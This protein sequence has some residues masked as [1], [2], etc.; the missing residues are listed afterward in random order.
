MRKN[1][2]RKSK[3][4]PIRKKADKLLKLFRKNNKQAILDI[5]W[6]D[7]YIEIMYG[8]VELRITFECLLS[9]R[10]KKIFN[11]EFLYVREGQ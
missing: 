4:K 6:S 1:K 3:I 10:V 11:R 7:E 2:S 8:Y 5:D 9:H